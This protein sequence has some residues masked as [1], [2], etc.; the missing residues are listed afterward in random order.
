MLYTFRK[1]RRANIHVDSFNI[2]L[3]EMLEI[4]KGEAMAV[5][6]TGSILKYVCDFIYENKIN[7][8]VYSFPFIKPFNKNKLLKILKTHKKIIIIEEHQASGG[9]GS[10]ILEIINDLIEEGELD[11]SPIIK[12]IAIPDKFYSVA[13]SQDYLRKIAG[14]ELNIK[15]FK[16]E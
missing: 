7:S 12:R 1:G 11:I 9:F 10:A 2:S 15:D 6:S 16:Y 5:F 13:G 8:S 14:L 4:Q 3:G